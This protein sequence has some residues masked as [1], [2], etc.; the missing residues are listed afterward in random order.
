MDQPLLDL[1]PEE[2]AR[3]LALDHLGAAA[4]AFP[5][6]KD[7]DDPEALHD[8]RVAL[9]RL[10]SC[11]RAYRP[12]LEESLPKKLRRRLRRL[13]HATG[14]G[15][16]T[17]VQ[18]E[19][20]RPKS[21][22]LAAFHRGGLAWLLKLLDERLRKS[23]S[24][25]T[26]QLEDEFPS[27]EREL[28]ERLSFYRIEIS[29]DPQARRPTFG[30]A[31]AGILRQQGAELETHMARIESVDDETE[32]HQARISAKRLRY[33]LEPLTGELPAAGPVVKRL[34]A[35]QDL[36][37][38]L[39]DAHLLEQELRSALRTAASER[40]NNLVE[41]SLIEIPDPKVLRAVRR[42]AWEAGLIALTRLNRSRRDDLFRKL[43]DEW[44]AG[45]EAKLFEELERVAE[46]LGREETRT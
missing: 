33:L 44:L 14:P 17:E 41:V 35:L 22:S 21:R 12:Q 28:R 3:R 11:L 38:E 34:K 37:G 1:T 16:D 15:R 7:P 8:F 46:T 18:I 20:L 43:K 29:L 5:R 13:A 4:A 31:T 27:L 40:A 10:R 23:W 24:E 9:R 19:W 45:G 2:G 32:A 36:L 6:L 39:H 26:G 30:E 25:L 42:R